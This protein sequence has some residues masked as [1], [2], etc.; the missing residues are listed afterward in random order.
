MGQSDHEEALRLGLYSPIF[1]PING[2]MMHA[3]RIDDKV[4]VPCDRFDQ[5]TVVSPSNLRM[6]KPRKIVWGHACGG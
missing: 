4:W 1:T 3:F 2:V 5:V 6:Q